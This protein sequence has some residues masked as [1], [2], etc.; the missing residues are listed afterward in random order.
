MAHYP[1]LGFVSGN[2]NVVLYTN[3][4]SYLFGG[5]LRWLK[6]LEAHILDLLGREAGRVVLR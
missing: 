4:L 6:P 1:S 3:I 5:V 2:S